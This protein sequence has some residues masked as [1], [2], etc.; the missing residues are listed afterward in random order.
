MTPISPTPQLTIRSD[1][2]WVEIDGDIVV[3]D[4]VGPMTHI[5]SGGAA[6]V[7]LELAEVGTL[8]APRLVELVARRVGSETE[9]L[10]SE[11]HGVL[12]QLVSIGLT[13]GSDGRPRDDRADPRHAASSSDG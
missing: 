10:R 6:L 12:E 11:I 7:W 4:P 1:V 3:Y 9:E 5:L 8:D 13:E 2:A